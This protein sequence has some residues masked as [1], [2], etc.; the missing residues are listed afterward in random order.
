MNQDF[1]TLLRKTGIKHKT[2]CPNSSHQNGTVERYWRALFEMA[3]CLLLEKDMSKMLWPYAVQTAA[4]I[5]NMCYS[6]R[7]KNTP[8]FSLTGK[9]PDLSKM[10]IFGSECYVQ[11]YDRKK[12]EAKCAKGVFGGYDKDSQY[13]WFITQELVKS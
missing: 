9:K 1:Q 2:S 11:E 5:R 12:L 3:R 4:L 6:N 10:W 7:I 13:I 8:Y